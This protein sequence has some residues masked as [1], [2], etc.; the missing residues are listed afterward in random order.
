MDYSQHGAISSEK[1]ETLAT[2]GS[3]VETLAGAG[4]AALAIIGL[5]GISSP[6]L[7]AVATIAAGVGFIVAGGAV[8]SRY[9]TLIRLLGE[10]GNETAELG[11]SMTSEFLGGV[12]GVVLGILSLLRLLPGILLPIAAIT[13]GATMLFG[14]AVQARLN[15]LEMEFHKTSEFSRKVIRGAV[16]SS[17]G[18]K[19]LLGLGSISLGILA[20][21]GVTPMLLTLVAMIAV[22]VGMLLTGSWLTARLYYA[23][24]RPLHRGGITGA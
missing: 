2:G 11:A 19:L 15:D 5:A 9:S 1:T 12:A 22:G 8:A 7:L 17:A 10:N 18:I 16:S 24:Q 20:L 13:F 4:A 14:I 23:R 6:L 21:V 3:I